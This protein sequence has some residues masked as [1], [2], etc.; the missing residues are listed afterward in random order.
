MRWTASFLHDEV[1]K[2]DVALSRLERELR[3]ARRGRGLRR[4]GGLH[5]RHLALLATRNR[6]RVARYWAVLAHRAALEH[7]VTGPKCDPELC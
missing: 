3:P 2:A 6:L 5:R 1:G 4:E 7:G